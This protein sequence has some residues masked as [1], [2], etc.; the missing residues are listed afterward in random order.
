MPTVA[1]I[2]IFQF[3]VNLFSLKIFIVFYFL[4]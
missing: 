2:I 3:N 1:L 4:L